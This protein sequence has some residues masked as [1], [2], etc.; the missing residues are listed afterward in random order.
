[1]I[2]EYSKQLAK[3][4]NRLDMPTKQR[5]R[6]AVNALPDGDIKQLTGRVNTWRLRVRD[7]RVLFSYPAKDVTLVEKVAPRG[8]IYREG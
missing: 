1:M 5:I 3:I 7:W 4:I 6:A 8:Q 2:I